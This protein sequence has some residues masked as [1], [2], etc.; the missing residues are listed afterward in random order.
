MYKKC[1][2]VTVEGKYKQNKNL[3]FQRLMVKRVLEK[4]VILA[5]ETKF[6]NK[7]SVLPLVE[8]I[9]LFFFLN[10]SSFLIL[11]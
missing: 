7:L 2:T 9:E 1:L 4:F 10:Y 8:G 11:V 3:H 6:Y 5:V